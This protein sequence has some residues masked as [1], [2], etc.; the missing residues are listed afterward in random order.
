MNHADGPA[1][2]PVA[3]SPVGDVLERLRAA[4][5]DR[6]SRDGR[7]GTDAQ[8][9]HRVADLMEDDDL[10]S[11]WA[12]SYRRGRRRRPGGPVGITTGVMAH[13]IWKTC[14][15]VACDGEPFAARWG[16]VCAEGG[17]A[18]ASA[19]GDGVSADSRRLTA[20]VLGVGGAVTPADV[21]ALAEAAA[22]RP[23]HGQDALFVGGESR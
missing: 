1:E 11:S 15:A 21:R 22:R 8:V 13:F 23:P 6:Q 4:R 17:V 5:F 19:W 14:T 2:V 3:L 7:L 10:R 12:R 18:A 9:L 20:L 16:R